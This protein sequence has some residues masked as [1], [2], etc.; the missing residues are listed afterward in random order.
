M[1]ADE[2]RT[3]GGAGFSVGGRPG[4]WRSQMTTSKLQGVIAAIATAVDDKGEPDC[5]CITPL[6]CQSPNTPRTSPFA[7]ASFESCHTYDATNR[8]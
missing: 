5:A 2:E 7:L 3:E 6:N 8:W 4:S 1:S